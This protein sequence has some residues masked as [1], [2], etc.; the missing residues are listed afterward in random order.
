MKKL[1]NSLV[2][3]VPTIHSIA[4]L[5]DN[6]VEEYADRTAFTLKEGNIM[7]D[8]TYSQMYD[9]VR[10]FA[11]YLCSQG[12]AGKKIVITG[13]NCYEWAITYLAVCWGVGIIVPI[14]RELSAEEL[15]GLIERSKA[16]CIV[17]TD[18]ITEKAIAA[19]EGKDIL[20]IPAST[21]VDC[22]ALG[23][24]LRR[25]GRSGELRYIPD[26]RELGILLFTSGTT[27][28]AKGVMLSQYNIASNI[29][30]VTRRIRVFPGDRALSILPLHHTYEC[31]VGFLTILYSG[32]SIC[33]NKNLRTLQNDLKLYRPTVLVAV[34]LVLETFHSKIMKTYEKI[35]GG[36]A[37]LNLSRGI[38]GISG[39]EKSPIAKKLF[40]AVHEVFGGKL[41]AFV[42]GAAAVDP[43]VFSDFEKFGFTVYIGYGL[44]ETAPVC[45]VHNDNYR[46][47]DDTGLPLIGVKI[48]LDNVNENGIGEL[49]VKGPNVMLGYYEDPA[50]T[51]EVIDDDGWFH[52]GDL[53]SVNE[54][55]AYKIVGRCKSMIV[56]NNGKKIFPEEVEHYID[57]SDLVKESLVYGRDQDGDTVV[58]AIVHPDYEAVDAL[59]A[60]DGVTPDST[61]YAAAVKK[62]IDK[63]VSDACKNLP[64]FKAVRRVFI[65][66]EEFIKTTT[67]K[68]RRFDP[69]NLKEY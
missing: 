3:N 57:Q 6:S 17:H 24:T 14:D 63:V 4:E 68:I 52:T 30:N 28:V 2:Y 58:S 23:N 37:I 66:P 26:P 5:L 47:A 42:C 16:A 64:Y 44:T 18:D 7:R 10:A 29:M 59:L 56:T 34:P 46:A 45:I 15:G 41:R 67:R 1:N 32:A 35:K 12:L 13:K 65:R 31:T 9:D 51:A 36:R 8:I 48:R 62:V 38:S 54:H 50:A 11:A 55:G 33:Y 60:K 27:G 39:R 69:E 40:S 61:E 49:C 25:H 20:R 53:A 21:V 22:I 19:C 43:R